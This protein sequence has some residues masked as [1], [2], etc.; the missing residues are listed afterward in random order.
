MDKKL[1]IVV[2]IIIS[3]LLTTFLTLHSRDRPKIDINSASIEAL[4]SLPDIGPVLAKRITEGRP[5]SDVW[6]LDKV[7]GIGPETI[8]SIESKVVAN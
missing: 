5:Y 4:E 2:L 6:E 8:K 1:L 3:I 7:K